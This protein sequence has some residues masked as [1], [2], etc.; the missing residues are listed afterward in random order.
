MTFPDPRPSR[1]PRARAASERGT[2]QDSA[3]NTLP[4]YKEYN[5]LALTFPRSREGPSTTPRTLPRPYDPRRS[6]LYRAFAARTLAPG[7]RPPPAKFSPEL[8]GPRAGRALG[9]R[10]GSQNR[11]AGVAR[12]A[13]GPGAPGRARSLRLWGRP[14]PRRSL[15]RSAL[16]PAPPAR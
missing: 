11:G 6:S 10:A 15:R 5:S 2:F 4:E 12:A 16:P 8:T 7:P 3:R 13:E 9:Q 1:P 14:G